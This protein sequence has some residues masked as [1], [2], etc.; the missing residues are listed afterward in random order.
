[1]DFRGKTMTDADLLSILCC[2]LTHQ[3]LREALPDE[4]AAF[5]S[6]LMAGL[7]REDG[8]VIYPVSNGIPLLLPGAAIPVKP[9]PSPQ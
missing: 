4:L 2:P 8:K 9:V 5:G 3:P 7:I 6:D 1:M